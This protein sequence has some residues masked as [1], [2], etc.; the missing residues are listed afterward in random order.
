MF[1]FFDFFSLYVCV[2]VVASMWGPITHQQIGE[3]M[4]DSYLFAH[5]Q[6]EDAANSFPHSKSIERRPV[7]MMV[8]A[9][10]MINWQQTTCVVPITGSHND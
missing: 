8:A 1:V 5:Q 9:L 4:P 3:R 7:L 6:Q 2:C 10:P